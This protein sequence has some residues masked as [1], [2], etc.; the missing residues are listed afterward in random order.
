MPSPSDYLY[1][2]SYICVKCGFPRYLCDCPAPTPEEYLCQRQCRANEI[3]DYLVSLILQDD[4][5]ATLAYQYHFV[6]LKSRKFPREIASAF[7]QAMNKYL[8][9]YCDYGALSCELDSDAYFLD[10]RD[11]IGVHAAAWDVIAQKVYECLGEH[12]Q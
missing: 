1:E 5:V 2:E 7:T 12:K 4:N 3:S 8:S 10:W 11:V 6:Y 9:Q